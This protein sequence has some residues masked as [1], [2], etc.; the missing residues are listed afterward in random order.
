MVTNEPRLQRFP[1][2]VM[3]SPG[4]TLRGRTL[5]REVR[6]MIFTEPRPKPLQPAFMVCSPGSAELGIST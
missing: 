2:T 6:T 4:S 3:E 5:N 1:R